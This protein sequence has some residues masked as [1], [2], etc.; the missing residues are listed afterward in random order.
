MPLS[1]GPYLSYAVICEKVLHEADGVLSLIRIVDHVTVTVVVSAPPG[2]Q[3]ASGLIP[4]VPPIS[5]TFVLGLKSGD[6][7]GSVPV[8]VWIQPPTRARWPEYETSVTL[9]GEENGANVILPLQFPGQDEGIYWFVVEVSGETLTQVPLRI[10]KQVI[11][12]T[13]PPR[14]E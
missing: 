1:N 8:K 11:T 10:S 5:V 9:E 3:A 4:P 6:F 14:H 12:Q 7:T 13:V 2:A